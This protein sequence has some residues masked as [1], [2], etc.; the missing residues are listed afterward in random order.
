MKGDPANVAAVEAYVRAY[1]AE[2]KVTVDTSDPIRLGLILSGWSWAGTLWVPWTAVALPEPD[3]TAALL[4]ICRECMK[5]LP[6]SRGVS[7]RRTKPR[8][9]RAVE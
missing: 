3:R 7:R 2:Y 5:S 8:K 6:G 1:F 9:S 4:E